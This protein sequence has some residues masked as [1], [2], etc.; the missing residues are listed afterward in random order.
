MATASGTSVLGQQT[1]LTG[2]NASSLLL[3]IA[4]PSKPL[5]PIIRYGYMYLYQYV[6]AAPFQCYLVEEG[7]VRAPGLY[8]KVQLA[9]FTPGALFRLDIV[10]QLPGI[11][12]TATLN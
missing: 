9:A 6:N 1:V 11:N 8:R 2:V 10:W 7:L 4:F 5:P 12:W 3:S